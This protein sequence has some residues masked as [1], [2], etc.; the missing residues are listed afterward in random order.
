[1]DPHNPDVLYAALWKRFRQPHR[2]DSGGPNGG[3]YK[4]TD[5]GGSWTKL[6]NGLPEGDTGKIGRAVR[7]RNPRIVMA[8]VEHGYQPQARVDGQP[9]P[10]YEDMSR[11]GT[12]IYR[13]DDGGASWSYV[14]RFNN[15]PFY[16]VRIWID[17]NKDQ[18]VYVLSGSAQISE[19]GGKTFA[20]QMGGISGDFHALWVDP[21]DLGCFYV[22]ND[23]GASLTHDG[24]E[25]FVMFDN[26]DLGQFY[27]VTADMRDP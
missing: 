19:D 26:M 6:T 13:S 7:L 16:Y 20:R 10:E 1:M 18:C 4:T 12:G 5:G 14:S 23:K 25:R 8:I 15:R 3:I 9:N 27:A 11:L 17:P 22:G 21:D 24:G 2:F